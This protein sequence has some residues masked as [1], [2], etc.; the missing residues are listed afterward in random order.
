MQQQETQKTQKTQRCDVCGVETTNKQDL[1][2]CPP[3]YKTDTQRLYCSRQCQKDDWRNGHKN[4]CKGA[5]ASAATSG[6]AP[7]PIIPRKKVIYF[8]MKKG[9][10]S[11]VKINQQINEIKGNPIAFT[12]LRTYLEINKPIVECGEWVK[13]MLM[14]I[15]NWILDDFRS[16]SSP[17]EL[18]K[19]FDG[20][21]QVMNGLIAKLLSELAIPDCMEPHKTKMTM[22]LNELSELMNTSNLEDAFMSITNN[23]QPLSY[24]ICMKKRY[25]EEQQTQSNGAPYIIVLSDD[26]LTVFSEIMSNDAEFELIDGG[27]PANLAQFKGGAN[28]NRKR[29]YKKINKCKKTLR[30][31]IK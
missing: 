10:A 8:V 23:I 14:F 22:F 1:K 12:H 30:K 27:N 18:N 20:R 17:S 6:K 11:R 16:M 25:Q 24:I 29:T 3:C 15:R 7:K 9:D 28:R 26:Q 19:K 2:A 4:V 21:R 13:K 5:Q 31:M